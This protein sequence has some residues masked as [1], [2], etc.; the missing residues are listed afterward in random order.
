[1][2]TTYIDESSPEESS[3]GPESDLTPTSNE[4][5]TAEPTKR[6][7][8]VQAESPR[9]PPVHVL[10]S[11]YYKATASESKASKKQKE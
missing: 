3:D 2:S 9:Y 10:K 6:R 4:D 5:P 8:R 1:M 11:S 7:R